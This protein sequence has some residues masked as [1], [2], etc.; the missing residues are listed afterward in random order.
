MGPVCTLENLIDIAVSNCR[1]LGHSEYRRGNLIV[2]RSNILCDYQILCYG[3]WMAADPRAGGEIVS[4]ARGEGHEG[5]EVGVLL[6]D[7]MG[8]A[9]G[10]GLVLLWKQE[11]AHRDPHGRGVQQSR[12]PTN[13]GA[14]KTNEPP[15]RGRGVGPEASDAVTTPLEPPT[16]SS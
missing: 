14:A 1:H 6:D 11:G 16:C 5:D 3:L 15:G 7:A 13:T 2:K 12:R 9:P 10:P 8:A 4:D